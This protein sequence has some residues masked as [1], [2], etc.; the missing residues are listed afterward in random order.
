MRLLRWV[1]CLVI[2]S[3][4]LGCGHQSP[5]T[6]SQANS[7]DKSRADAV[8]RVVQNFMTQAHLKAAI[9]RVT[10]D[11]KEVVTQAIGD[12]M[13]G[14]PAT[15]DM[16]FRN[17]AVAISYVS[18][19]LLKLVDEKKLSLDD[20]LSKWLPDFPNAGRVTLGQ[21]AQ[22]TAGYPDYV[23]GNDQ[24]DNQIYA[25]PFQQ[26]TTQDILTQISGHPL[27]YDPGTNWNYA[28]TDYVLLGLALEKATGQ[29]MPTL[30]GNEVL[31]PLGLKSTTNSDTP[32][33]PWP[34]LHTFSSERRKA[35]KIPAGTPFYEESTYWNPSW[36]ITHG[37]IQ[38]TNI[39]DMEATAVGVGSGKLLSADSYKK[40]VSTALRGKTHTQPGCPTCFDQ[41][42][43][44]TY[45]LGIITSGDWLLQNPL[46]SGCAG[47]EAYLP[48]Q[49]IAIAVAVTYAPEAFDDQG[50]YSNQADILF[51]KI[52][53]VVAPNAAPPMP[54]GR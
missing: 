47:V 46:F 16:H 33:I 5:P 43:G 1:A 27:L 29:D 50:N 15:T 34:V 25:N 36:T 13:T 19:L 10:V 51:R 21:L 53:A 39:F 40:M 26:T 32:E 41:N 44:Y 28:H 20:R 37:A 23:I 48:A 9:I 8:M 6:A 52:G 45:G 2:A 54:P 18:T 49:K 12:S 11:G 7:A 31:G 42:E 30:L 17:G 3:V 24:F 38:T 22:M 35:L 14:V 4:M